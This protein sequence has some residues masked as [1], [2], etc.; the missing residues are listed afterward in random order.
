MTADE[1]IQPVIAEQ[2]SWTVNLNTVA[3]TL[4]A[5]LVSGLVA[6]VLARIAMRVVALLAGQPPEFSI[7][8]TIGIGV[9]FSALGIIV[10]LIFWGLRFVLPGGRLVQG[11]IFGVLL[12]ALTAIPFFQ[13]T[14]G[15]FG[16]ASP[17]IGAG[18]FGSIAWSDAMLLALLLPRLERRFALLRPVGGLWFCTFGLSLLFALVR[19]LALTAI[20]F[21]TPAAI[22]RFY[23][24]LGVEYQA[25]AELHS[26]LLFFFTVGYCGLGAA[27]FW[28]GYRTTAVK[29]VAV[30]TLLLGGLFIPLG[31]SIQ[32]LATVYSGSRGEWLLWALVTLSWLVSAWLI[33]RQ[34]HRRVRLLQQP[35]I[36]RLVNGCASAVG[37]FLLWWAI[38]MLIP[39]L[40]LRGLSGFATAFATP[41]YLWP[42]L[43]LPLALIGASA[44]NG[45][46]MFTR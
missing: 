31:A 26:L 1:T 45:Q 28:R 11:M 18:L 33:R 30:S 41:L 25:I 19:L 4:G 35:V 46:D 32:R 2:P 14:D 6:G 38:I 9:V 24:W 20:P 10:A 15:E 36:R 23:Q 37:L 39:G 42:W 5:G 43:T 16:I 13:A 40:Q 12:A 3:A 7:V 34:I 44:Q 17:W 21:R 22:Q 27:L 8:G 29:L